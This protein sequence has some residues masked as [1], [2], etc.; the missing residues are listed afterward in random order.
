MKEK[1]IN[2]KKVRVISVEE[3]KSFATRFSRI[4]QFYFIG[5]VLMLSAGI[6]FAQEGSHLLPKIFL[7]FLA[8]C[9]LMTLLSFR[10]S[11]KAGKVVNL[12][13][14]NVSKKMDKK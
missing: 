4:S 12:I 5:A 2:G 9:V 3:L 13:D 8:F 6:H 10:I 14:N 11:Y 7:G 1:M